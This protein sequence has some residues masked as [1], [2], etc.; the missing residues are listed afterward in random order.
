M[1]Y[2]VICILS[3]SCGNTVNIP[4]KVKTKS[5]ASGEVVVNHNFNISIEAFR[6]ACELEH[7]DVVP[8]EL[9][10]SLIKE[11]QAKR[12]KDFL[13]TISNLQKQAEQEGN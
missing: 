3:I 9:K 2:I 7:K 6:E 13:D 10:D 4:K 8:Q 5:E 12:L 1:R 11:C